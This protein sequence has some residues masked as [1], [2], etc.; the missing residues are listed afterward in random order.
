MDRREADAQA[1]EIVKRMTIEEKIS[2]L[3]FLTSD[4]G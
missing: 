2:Q 3:K 1:K 4:E